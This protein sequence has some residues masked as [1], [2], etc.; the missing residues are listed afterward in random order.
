MRKCSIA[1]VVSSIA[2]SV[3]LLC[4]C[5]C[6]RTDA[7]TTDADTSLTIMFTGDVLLDRGVRPVIEHR[8][9]DH[10]FADVAPIFA[11]ADAVVINLECPLTDSRSPLGKQFIFRAEPSWAEGLRRAGITHAAMANNHTNDQGRTGISD[12]YRHL[13]TAGITPLGYGEN[14]EQ[15]HEPVVIER[16]NVKVALFNAAMMTMENWHLRPDRTDIWQPTDDELVGVVEAYREAN[17]STKIICVLHWGVEFQS[18]P[19]RQQRILAHRL[20][21]V[22]VDAVVGHHPHV[23]QPIEVI[24]DRTI[25]Y[26]SLGNFVFDQHPPLT[27]QSMIAC[28]TLSADSIIHTEI[29]IE[30][31]G[32]VPKQMQGN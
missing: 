24:N 12:T 9:I 29:K 6:G 19:N 22:G 8:G 17:P 7:R 27:R 26:Y 2:V 18:M 25:V 32:C 4:S 1:Q 10:V 3:V 20:S 30:I 31:S 16:G 15:R 11:R 28:L 14:H 21:R 23:L 13:Q 5:N